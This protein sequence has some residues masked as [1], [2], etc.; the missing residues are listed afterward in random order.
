MLY[1]Q[2]DLPPKANSVLLST[3]AYSRYHLVLYLLK[4]P[5]LYAL[6]GIRLAVLDYYPGT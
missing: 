3:H 4:V 2:E 1:K 5:R 6:H